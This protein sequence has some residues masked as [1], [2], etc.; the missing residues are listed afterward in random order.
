MCS[1]NGI[2]FSSENEESKTICN[3]TVESKQQKSNVPK[4][5]KKRLIV[6]SF[7]IKN[8]YRETNKCEKLWDYLLL[9]VGRVW[10]ATLGEGTM[11]VST[12]LDTWAC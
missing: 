9:R 2:P 1:N 12:V 5:K 7:Y 4:K 11:E 10:M 3:S 8:K 6:Y